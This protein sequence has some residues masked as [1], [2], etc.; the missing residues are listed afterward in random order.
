MYEKRTLFEYELLAISDVTLGEHW[1]HDDVIS[2][3]YDYIYSYIPITWN[4]LP[5]HRI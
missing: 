5:I 1:F 2:E 4:T 3:S